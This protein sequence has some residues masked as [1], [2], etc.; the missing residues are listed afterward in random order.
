M[1]LTALHAANELMDQHIDPN[2]PRSANGQLHWVNSAETVAE[3]GQEQQSTIVFPGKGRKVG[4]AREGGG[5]SSVLCNSNC[6]EQKVRGLRSAA[7]SPRRLNGQTHVE[8]AVDVPIALTQ[9]LLAFPP[10]NDTSRRH[11]GLAFDQHVPALAGESL[12]LHQVLGEVWG[13][14]WQG[15]KE[16]D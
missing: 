8:S 15:R 13:N 11:L 3:R 14:G 5:A 1:T 16:G 12:R 7:L 10:G 4:S 6:F 2:L 9:S